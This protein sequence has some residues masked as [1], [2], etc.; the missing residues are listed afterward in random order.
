[1]VGAAPHKVEAERSKWVVVAPHMV[2]VAL[3]LVGV[4]LQWGVA[5]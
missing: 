2:A 3:L 4:A 5:A 1:M